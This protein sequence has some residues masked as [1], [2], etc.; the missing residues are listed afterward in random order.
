VRKY[1]I[2]GLF[3]A[4][5]LPVAARA[6]CAGGLINNCPAAVNPQPGD[7]ALTWQL[8]Q[9]PH[10]RKMTL[11][12]IVAGA[13]QS[14]LTQKLSLLPSAS[15]GAGL[16]LGAG[17]SP[18]TCTNGDVWSTGTGLFS[19][20]N[21]VPVGPYGTGG[22]NLPVKTILTLPPVTAANAGQFAF[23]SDCPNGSQTVGSATGCPYV[24]NTNGVWTPL[25]SP[26]TLS[27]TVGGQVL[28]L[29]GTTNNQGNGTKIQLASGGFVAGNALA[30]DVNGNAIDSGVPPSGGSGGGGTVANS[31]VA[32]A[33]PFYPAAG[34]T[35]A[36]LGVVPN[37]VL[38]TNSS[39]VPSEGTTLPPSLIIP[40]P[41]I[42]SPILTGTSSIATATMTGKLTTVASAAAGA[43]LNIPPGAAPSAPANG[44][45]WDTTV[46]T[47]ARVNGTT[48]GPYLYSLTTSGPL[49]GG[50]AGPTLTLTCATCATTTNGGALTATA[51]MAISAGGVISLGLQPG[52]IVWIAD[53]ATTVHNDTY[54]VIEKWPWVNSG[55]ISSI[56][57]RTGGTSTPTFTVSLQIAGTPV[58]GC[59]GLGVSSSS[60]TT[61]TCTGA[62]TITN[63]QSLALVITGT[64]GSPASAAVQIN[65]SRPAS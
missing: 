53:S 48:Q 21:S 1:F 44:D 16:N 14:P 4:L 26:T 36:P 38:M 52:P 13:L 65:Y 55:T 64:S 49:G 27:L 8:S 51:P 11:Q 18:L 39:G 45:H 58:T 15:N 20:V 30:F 17:S 62:N 31:S 23:V 28:F 56:T 29:G 6:Q 40:S 33:V 42:S 34:S 41:T 32:N 7:E 12:Q 2:W 61:V 24:V 47:F 19:C 46:G 54:N 3:L 22:S 9:G 59:N 63:G 50:G 10:T 43:G 25:P 37:S 35:I 5:L 60:D 57:Y